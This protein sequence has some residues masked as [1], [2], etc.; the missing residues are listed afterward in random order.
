MGVYDD[1]IVPRVTDLLLGSAAYGKLRRR[2]LE[3]VTGEV[4]EL[5]FGSG[6]NLPCYPPA[7]TKVYAVEPSATARRLAAKRI[8]AAP[9]PVEFVGLDGQRVDMPDDSVDDAVTS[10]TLC[11][12]PDVGAALAEVRRVLR[13]GGRLHFLEHGLSDD[14]RVARRQRRWDRVQQRL[15]G[16][17]HLDRPHDELIRGAGFELEDLATFRIAGPKVTGF[18][19]AGRAVPA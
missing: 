19:Y 2:A 4:L 16:G 14:D 15:A 7:V 11:T 18:M 17:C 10:W 5:G 13:P 3:R 6:T 9:F 8:A 12:I 1:R